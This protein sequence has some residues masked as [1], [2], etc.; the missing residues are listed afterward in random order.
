M[1]RRRKMHYYQLF[2]KEE[3]SNEQEN[4]YNTLSDDNEINSCICSFCCEKICG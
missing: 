4:K 2:F 3:N 1:M